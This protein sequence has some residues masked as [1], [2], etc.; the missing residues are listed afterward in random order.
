MC[1]RADVSVM[2]TPHEAAVAEQAL[3]YNHNLKLIQITSGYFKLL[4]DLIMLVGSVS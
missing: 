1:V 3:A 4:H 2:D